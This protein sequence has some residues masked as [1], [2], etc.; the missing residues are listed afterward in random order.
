MPHHGGGGCND[1]DSG[2][3]ALYV[4]ALVKGKATK[5]ECNTPG[6]WGIGPACKGASESVHLLL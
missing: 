3:S 2:V 1:Y 6:V 5:E 4:Q